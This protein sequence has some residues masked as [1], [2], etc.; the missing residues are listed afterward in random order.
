MAD[1]PDYKSTM[2]LPQTEFPMRANLAKRE[3][4]WL[5]FW[6][7]N[8][9]YAKSLEVNE[10][11]ETFILHDGPPYANGHIHMG[12][13]FNKVFKDLIVKYKTMRGYW[14][15]YVPGLGL[16][17]PAHRA[18]GREGPRCREDGARSP[19]RSCAHSVATTR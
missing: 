5:E 2:N 10:G 12:T 11:G 6:A 9:I 19:R 16:S 14:S 17:R 4:E 7:E 1:K 15:P 13:A 18:P 8:D 3:P